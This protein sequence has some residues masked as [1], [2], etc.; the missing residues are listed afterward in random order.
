MIRVASLACFLL[1]LLVAGCGNECARLA[2][3]AC[4][5]HGEES[6]VC[7]SRANELESASSTKERLCRRALLLYT[8]LPDSELSQ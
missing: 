7:I 5:Q 6:V 8:T 4:T 3:H 2:E 1:A